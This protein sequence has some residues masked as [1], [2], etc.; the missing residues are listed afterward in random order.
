MR[1]RIRW[2]I[3]VLMTIAWADAVRMKEGNRSSSR[4]KWRKGCFGFIYVIVIVLSRWVI[5]SYLYSHTIKII[6]SVCNLG[7]YNKY[8]YQ[9]LQISTDNKRVNLLKEQI[10]CLCTVASFQ[11]ENTGAYCFN[12]S[13]LYDSQN[14][15][16]YVF[17]ELEH[18]SHN[19]QSNIQH[20]LPQSY[21]KQQHHPTKLKPEIMQI[22][23]N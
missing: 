1:R 11:T 22:L 23:K 9:G 7:P 20:F 19:I 4:T 21:S 8:E 6:K 16:I 2:N 15:S 10:I 12:K 5:P 14:Y 3:L 17:N 13:K 18:V